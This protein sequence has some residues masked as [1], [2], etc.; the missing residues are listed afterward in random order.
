MHISLRTCIGFLL[1]ERIPLG[2]SW[3]HCVLSPALWA[4]GSHSSRQI[5]A[6]AGVHVQWHDISPFPPSSMLSP[7]QSWTFSTGDNLLP[8][9]LSYETQLFLT[10]ELRQGLASWT[11]PL[12]SSI[13]HS[14]VACVLPTTLLSSPSVPDFNYCLLAKGPRI[15]DQVSLVTCFLDNSS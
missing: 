14:Q 6:D 12:L 15:D 4:Q 7:L 10:R 9:I 2:C 8:K 13:L 3:H 11:D 5:P 1:T